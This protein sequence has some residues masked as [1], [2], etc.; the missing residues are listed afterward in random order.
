MHSSYDAILIPDWVSVEICDSAY[1]KKYVET[2]LEDG[3]PIF[4]IAE[5]NY[6]R[7][8]NGEEGNLYRIVYAASSTLG[9][10]K[11]FLRRHV[12]VEDTLNEDRYSRWI[13][14]L[15]NN[16]PLSANSNTSGRVIKKNA[17]EISLTIL[18]EIFS[19]YCPPAES[20]TIYTQDRDAYDYQK[21]AHELLKDVFDN[22]DSVE[23]S[24]KSNDFLLYQMFRSGVLDIEAIEKLRK[25]ER[26][27]VY[28]KKRDDE[29]VAMVTARVD[30]QK[31]IELLQD[32]R[33]QI[34][35]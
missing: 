6:D 21:N 33:I 1:R 10:M 4:R 17:G 11:S 24:Y 19:W 28:T 18:A 30:N 35:F 20:I 7:L 22:R 31:F 2:L 5:E 27:V 8:V 13:A 32:E 25:D 26:V 12:Q 15:Y 23:V 34:I 14:E 29:S 16:W 3:L 9:A